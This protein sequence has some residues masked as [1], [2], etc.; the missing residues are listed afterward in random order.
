MRAGGWRAA[1]GI[2]VIDHDPVAEAEFWAMAPRGVTVNAARFE[3]PR[4]PGTSDYGVDPARV[5]AESPDVARGLGCLGNMRLDAICVC[6]TTSSFFGG[7]EFDKTFASQ[8]S[9]LAQGIPVLT[10]AQAITAAMTAVGIHHPFV[11]VPPWFKA[12]IVDA[13]RAYLTEAGFIPAGMRNFEL[14]RGWRDLHPWEMWDAGAQWEVRPEEVYRQIRRTMPAGADGV[15]IAGNGL[16]CVEAIGQLEADL[17]VP[18]ITSN[19]A[20]LWYCLRTAGTATADVTGY[21]RLFSA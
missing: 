16:S 18:V 13:G 19:Q 14:G 9:V 11:V 8:A 4:K 10:A 12:E 20:C 7:V 5:V 3:S 6:F 21:G 17:G 1:L 2:L 15:L